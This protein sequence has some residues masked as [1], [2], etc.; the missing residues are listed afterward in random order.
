M[1]GNVA[2]IY[3]LERNPG[4]K[5]DVRLCVVT[6]ISLERKREKKAQQYNWYWQLTIIKKVWSIS[7]Q[8]VPDDTMAAINLSE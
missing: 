7:N 6:K 1:S 4:K 2:T 5:D 8:P 3:D